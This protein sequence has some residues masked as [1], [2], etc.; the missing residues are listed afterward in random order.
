MSTTLTP[1]RLLAARSALA[2]VAVTTSTALTLA[3]TAP[4][5][6]HQATAAAPA[7]VS[8]NVEL[9]ASVGVFP[10]GPPFQL[11]RSAGFGSPQE[12]LRTLGFYAGLVPGSAGDSLREALRNMAAVVDDLQNLNLPI[13]GD[14]GLAIEVP[15]PG[16]AGTLDSIAGLN[17]S[18]A[19][20]NGVAALKLTL[21]AMHIPLNIPF[22]SWGFSF[23]DELA[24]VPGWGLGGT[25]VALASPTLINDHDY[26]RTIVIA[27]LVRNTSRPG[28]GLVALANPLSSVVGL[29]LSNSDGRVGNHNFTVWDLAATYDLLSDAPSTV[30]NPLAWI[31]SGMGLLMPTYLL[32]ASFT[33]DLMS[34]L[35]VEGMRH[36]SPQSDDGNLYLTYDSGNLP[37]LEMFAAMPRIIG[38][39]PGFGISTPLSSSLNDVLTQLVATG[40]QN[41]TMTVDD[42]G[43]ATFARDWEQSSAGTQAKFWTSPLTWQ[44]SLQLPQTV[45][46]ATLTGLRDNLLNPRDQEFEVFGS[47]VIGDVLYRNALTLA[48]A[49]IISAGLGL[50][51]NTLNPAFNAIEQLLEPIAV[52]LDRVTASAYDSIDRALESAS[53]RVD[54]S[55]DVIRVNRAINGAGERV[56]SAVQGL[57]PQSAAV[58][59]VA[60]RASTPTGT[61]ADPAALP[62]SDTET[63]SLTLPVGDDVDAEGAVAD[64]TATEADAG[65]DAEPTAAET[66]P[67]TVEDSATS[68]D[69]SLSEAVTGDDADEASTE[70]RPARGGDGASESPTRTGPRNGFERGSGLSDAS[71]SGKRGRPAADSS[72]DRRTTPSERATRSGAGSASAGS[73]RSAA[74]SS[75]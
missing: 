52:A 40:Y 32:P 46:D 31:N 41:V 36:Q 64:S 21:N 20:Q 8:E 26:H 23:A 14:V 50:L 5:L 60:R 25:N 72:Q 45:F 66:D 55:D 10:V 70:K 33:G 75:D 71:A 24:L 34:L 39:L 12:A 38:Y 58:P 15:P 53:G 1:T 74:R 69:D 16:P 13:L 56:T 3:L 62:G 67:D 44:Q 54:L 68:P 17:G 4:S 65:D 43:V 42:R 35:H 22:N 37:L 28:G 61:N 51:Q 49:E 59:E 27:A 48:A 19:A 30:F 47:T 73:S 7:A 29:N 63:V 9:A 11:L 57:V 6:Q 2:A 18:V